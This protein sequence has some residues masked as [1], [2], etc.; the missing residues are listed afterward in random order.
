MVTID[1]TGIALGRLAS[2]SAKKAV[3]GEKIILVNCENAIISGR[4]K[5]ILEHYFIKRARG[6]PYKGP[7]IHRKA[8]MIVKRAIRG[9]L[10]YKQG[11]GKE[12][13][14]RIV[15]YNSIPKDITV[16]EDVSKLKKRYTSYMTL[17]NLSQAIGNK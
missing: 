6:T 11:T 4:K 8:A 5:D 16:E 1:A 10:N 14:K 13:F 15:C 9:M 3:L 2:Y 7:F 17:K 12:A